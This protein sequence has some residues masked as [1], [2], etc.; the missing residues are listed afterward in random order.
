MVGNSAF[1]FATHERIILR[2]ML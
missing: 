1:T 2:G